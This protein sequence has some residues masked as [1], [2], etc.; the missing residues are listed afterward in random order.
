ML[1]WK[2]LEGH[3]TKLYFDGFLYGKF[4]G[5]QAKIST[6]S[7]ALDLQ[8]WVI[9]N[10]LWF[11]IRTNPIFTMW[12]G[13]K[14]KSQYGSHACQGSLR[15]IK[16]VTGSNREILHFFMEVPIE[17]IVCNVVEAVGYYT[18]FCFDEFLSSKFSV[19]RNI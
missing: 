11:L 14:I 6:I 9:E 15:V 17:Y 12:L 5:C 16:R 3:C 19:W 13:Y 7:K 10:H 4:S 8:S 2:K 1:G 18:K